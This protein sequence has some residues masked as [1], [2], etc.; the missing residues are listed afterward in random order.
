MCGIRGSQPVRFHDD[1]ERGASGMISRKARRLQ[2]WHQRLGLPSLIST[3]QQLR[4]RSQAGSLLEFAQGTPS[5]D[6]S[7]DINPG[8]SVIVYVIHV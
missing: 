1:R 4:K 8:A 3:R 5:G 2:D 6:Y 7:T